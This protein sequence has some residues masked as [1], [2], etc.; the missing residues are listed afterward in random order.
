MDFKKLIELWEY[1]ESA[2]ASEEKLKE[3]NNLQSGVCEFLNSM[4]TAQKILFL[5]AAC[6][7]KDK[8]ITELVATVEM[9]KREIDKL[10]AGNVHTGI[11]TMPESESEE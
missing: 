11:G 6:E 10:K 7:T 2:E 8:M 4:K 9:L 3:F 1:Y 5:E